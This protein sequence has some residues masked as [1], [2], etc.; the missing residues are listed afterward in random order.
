MLFSVF[1]PLTMNQAAFNLIA[2]SL[3][4]IQ[5]KGDWQAF[6]ELVLN[7]KSHPA[8]YQYLS[9][10][11]KKENALHP[12]NGWGKTEVIAKKHL[13]FVL[14]H[15]FD[16]EYRTL[17]LSITQ[18][19]SEMVQ[20]R[21]VRFI[22]ESPVL[23]AIGLLSTTG[24]VKFP[25]PQVRYFTGARTEFKT[26]KK[27]GEAIEGKEYGF[28]SADD[29]ALE[30]HLEFLR[31]KILLPRLRKYR[32]SQL[33]FYATPKG[34]NAYFRVVSD[35]KRKGGYVQGGSSFDNPWIDHELLRYQ[36]TTWSQ[37]K[38]D[39]IIM[40]LFID[41]AEM[42][43]ASRVCTLFDESLSLD[44]AERGRRYVEGWDL[45]RGRKGSQSDQTVGYR[46]DVTAK[47]ARIVK[48]W[49]FQLP[50]T[51][52]EREN[53]NV[54]EQR[55]REV[56]SIEREIRHAHYESDAEVYLDSTGVGDTLYG[57][58]MD[59]ARPVDFRGGRKDELL[60][61]LQAV[62]DAGLLRSPF[63]PDLADEMTVY[64]RDDKNLDT[65]NVM[66]L[67]IA[68]QGIRIDTKHYGTRDL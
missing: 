61:H 16:S 23:R 25:N 60:D 64:Q 45:A 54:E 68:A 9:K 24:V 62:I 37:A 15:L 67:A 14:S 6:D 32:D 34:L 52:Q 7:S 29:I 19:Q 65:D 51:E 10:S 1:Y 47:P 46:I 13:R 53:I 27:K 33:D 57:I 44:E 38:I 30:Q 56:S 35:I 50:W 63:I 41:T 28:I 17:N 20:D 26:T 8:Q 40:G 22:R 55:E 43:F 31:D 49:A 11:V 48:R 59:I 12:G 66:S 39:Q 2:F 21:I 42:M 18:E 58:L 3:A 5:Q 36:M 4:E